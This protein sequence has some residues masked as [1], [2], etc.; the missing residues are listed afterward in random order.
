M[1]TPKSSDYKITDVNGVEGWG[2]YEKS[3]INTDRLNLY[4]TKVYYRKI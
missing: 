1:T 4:F 3:G 2:L